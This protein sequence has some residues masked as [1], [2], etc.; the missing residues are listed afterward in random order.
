MTYSAA[1][2]PTS[3]G[4]VGA[5]LLPAPARTVSALLPPGAAVRAIRSY[6]YFHGVHVAIPLLTLAAWTAAAALL[7]RIREGKC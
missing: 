5:P 1:A 2:M 6:C 4:I 3:G 7:L